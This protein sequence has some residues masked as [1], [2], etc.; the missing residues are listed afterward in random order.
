MY[1]NTNNS[2]QHPNRDAYLNFLFLGFEV[3]LLLKGLL[4]LLYAVLLRLRTVFEIVRWSALQHE[5]QV[6]YSTAIEERTAI[7][8]I[9]MVSVSIAALSLAYKLIVEF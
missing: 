9:P 4:P 8:T 6:I 7:S 3:K 2:V 5:N 1:N